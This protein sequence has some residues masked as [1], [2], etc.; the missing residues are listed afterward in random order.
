MTDRLPSFFVSHGAPSLP[1][2]QGSP[3]RAFLAGLGAALP[4]PRAILVVSAHWDTAQPTLSTAARPETIHDF[5]GFPRELYALGYPAP[6]APA[7]AERAAGLLAEAGIAA[8]LDPAQGLDHGAWVPLLL[9]FPEAEIPVV[10]LSVQS[11]RDAA[12]HLAL[13]RAL[14]PLAEEGVLILGSGG[15]VHN[16]RRLQIE[17]ERTAGWAQ[18]FEDWLVASVEAGDEAA[19]AGWLDGA[20]Q[21]RLAQPSD[22]HFLPLFVA[23]GAGDGGPGRTLHRGFEHGSL[24]MAAFAWG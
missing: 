9:A 5:Y 23:L 19:L 11:R 22:E 1:L 17:R 16:L 3:A 12:S 7:L 4:R 20:P 14:R 10:Q 8:R 15:A 18:A 24:S 6:G 13:G 21:A 2:E